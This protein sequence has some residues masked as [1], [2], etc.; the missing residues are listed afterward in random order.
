MT[1]DAASIFRK[2]YET[3]S[4]AFKALRN[5]A[6]SPDSTKILREWGITDAARMIGRTPPTLRNLEDLGKIPKARII[7]NGKRAERTYNLQEINNLRDYFNTRPSKPKNAK[8][9]VMGFG[10]FKGGAGKTTT[11]INAAQFFALKGYRVLFI[12]CDSQGSATQMFGYIPDED[13]SDEDTLLSIL[14]GDTNDINSVIKKTYWD[15]LDL[16]PSNLSLYNAELIIPTQISN[17]AIQTGQQLRFFDRL[18]SSLESIKTT[19]DII[20]ID[21][22]PSM[23][24]ISINAL[25]ASDALVIEMPPIIV[26]FAS[27]NQFFKMVSEVFERLPAKEFS[28]VRI[29]LT[30]Y[31]NRKTASNI[32]DLMRAYFSQYLMPEPMVES[33]VIYKAVAEMQ[34]LYE[35]NTLL[36]DRKTYER[37]IQ[38][39]NEINEELEKLIK[40]SWE[41]MLSNKEI[42][43]LEAETIYG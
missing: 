4:A 43:E 14:T 21:C 30:K 13:L 25:F 2:L 29:L 23:G 12:D 6:L 18:N 32:K 37:V 24:M 36:T 27:T 7:S 3:G 38:R 40:L 33:E 5:K 26:D 31:N 10:N 39:A 11:A 8:S 15:S 9:L 42:P 34:T 19:Y 17:H 41:K 1:S 20:M 22:P 28:F 16:I 35:F